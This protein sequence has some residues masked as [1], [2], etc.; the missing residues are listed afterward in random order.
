MNWE[1]K[2]VAFVC[3]WCTYAGADLAGVTRTQY[4]PNVRVI[5]VPC[6]GRVDPL[7]I[8]KAFEQGA[9]GVLVSGCHPGDCHY[10][11]GNFHAKRRWIFFKGLT[12]FIG[13]EAERV[14]Y[15][16]V[17]ASE[18]NK[19]A[20]LVDDVTEAVRRL[21]PF[22]RYHSLKQPEPGAEQ[23][24]LV[25]SEA[26]QPGI[27]DDVSLPEE[28]PFAQALREKAS[29]LL[30]HGEVKVVIGYGW[31][32]RQRRIVPVFVTKP[33]EV[34]R[35]TFNPLCVNNL[36]VYL[37]RKQQDIAKMGKP[38][39]VAKG[40][41]IKTIVVLLQEEQIA[42]EGV[43]ILGV[44]CSGV[45]YRQELWSGKPAPDLL[46]PK[47]AGCDVRT[48]RLADHV[49]GEPAAS[50]ADAP[51]VS[52]VQRQIEALDRKDPAERWEFWREHFD[53]CIKCYACSQVCPL[54]YCDRCIAEKNNPQWVETSAH[55]QGNCSWNLVRAIH[56]AGRCTFCGEC[57]RVCP[58]NIPLNLINRKLAMVSEEH[59][60]YRSGYDE[61]A[62]PPMV[63][64]H[65]DDK[66]HFIR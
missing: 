33:E 23:S 41:D 42:R 34:S 60:N 64:Y 37:P 12:D 10:I 11:A 36:A 26:W 24:Q 58:A 51:G 57:D 19:W 6:T 8:V 50:A 32:K 59:F 46:A 13:I 30:D 5:R 65:P 54:C 44:S 29:E 25:W 61:K 35:L 14:Q 56:L 66:E 16:W 22:T 21:G 31:A 53:R 49:I 2:I 45:V 63:V 27:P 28:A 20:K 1:P 7:F 18:A 43:V 38:A 62:H 15:A 3:N 55:P 47:C 4:R 40:C 48:P 9:D 39:I 17:S 52:E